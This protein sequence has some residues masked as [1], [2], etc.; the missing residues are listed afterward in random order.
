MIDWKRHCAAV[1]P[2]FNEAGRIAPVVSA[3]RRHL[4]RVIVVDDG[5]SD[6]TRAEAMAA[7]AAVI[8]QPENGGK[9]A[10]LRAGWAHA[11]QM[12]LTWALSM[13]GDGQ[14]ASADIP[15]FFACAEKTSVRLI[16]G[17][18]M[19]QVGDMPWVRRWA[20]RWM[21]RCL[22]NLT[23]AELPDSQC[24]FR[25]VHLESLARL[26]LSARRF[27]IESEMLVAFLAA[28]LPVEFVT[29]QVLYE[30][31]R[32]KICPWRDTWRWLRWWAGQQPPGANQVLVGSAQTAERSYHLL[33][34]LRADRT[35]QRGVLTSAFKKADLRPR[36]PQ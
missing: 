2:C 28:R 12:G 34:C 10:A 14:H 4:P 35:P 27:E 33:C 24:G 29:I 13:D 8:R 3:V 18:R 7:G 23:G 19:G 26:S 6:A 31:S 21:S 36:P 25:L 30:S 32:S 11:R 17:N 9:G 15:K 20:N 1:I 22:S 5:S 16:I